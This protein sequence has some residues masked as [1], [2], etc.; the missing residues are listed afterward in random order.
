MLPSA[1]V[2]TYQQYKLDTDSV[3]AWLAST[4]KSLGYSADLLDS[5]VAATSTSKPRASGG[6]LKGKARSN[7]KKT[8]AAGASSFAP[9]PKPSGPK[10]VISVRSFVSLAE[11]IAEKAAPVPEVF[12]TVIDRVIAARSKFGGQ[13]RD[14][15]EAIDP[16]S[17]AKHQHFVD[18]LA[19]VRSVLSPLMPAV[20][21]EDGQSDAARLAN[22]FTGLAVYEP[23]QEF[24]NLPDVARPG[25]AQNDDSTYEAQPERSF[26]EAIFALDA[27]INDLGHV[28]SHIR[29]IWSNHKDG[30]FEV[31]PAAVATDTA[32]AL[33]R[34]LIDE[35]LPLLEWNGGIGDLLERYYLL[36]CIVQGWKLEDLKV[37]A[38]V[39]DNFNYKTYDIADGTYLLP[40]RLLEAFIPVV[41]ERGQ[42]PIYKEGMFGY[43]DPKSNRS[44]KTGLQKF[45]DDRALL[46]PFFS[47]I[48]TA[49]RG[50]DNWP[51]K[52]E[53]Y[54]GVEELAKTKKVPFYAAFAAQIFLD[55]TYELGEHVERG[56]DAFQE[57]TN[58]MNNDVEQHFEFHSKLKI[59]SW[60]AAHDQMLREFQKSIQ[61]LGKDPLRNVQNRLLARMGAPAS[62]MPMYLIF[63][64]SPVVSGLM[65]FHFRLVYSHVGRAVADAWGSVQYAQ[66]LYNAACREGL[67]GREDRWQDMEVLYANLGEG[68]FYVGGEAPKTAADYFKK[69]SLQMGTSAAAMTGTRRR[70]APLASGAGPRGLKEGCPVSCMFKGRYVR[71]QIGPSGFL[72]PERVDQIIDLSLFEPIEPPNDG[73]GDGLVLGRIEHPAILK[74]KAKKTMAMGT[75]KQQRKKAA[76]GGR[77]TPSQLIQ[78]LT[79]ALQAETL[80]LAFPLL[81]FHRWCWRLLR[82]VKESCDSLLTTRYGPGYLETERQLPFVVGWILMAAGGLGNDVP[83]RRM[84]EIAAG[85]IGE[86]GGCEAGSIVSEKILG[87]IFD[88]PI[89]FEEEDA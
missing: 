21:D 30:L 13:L 23:S 19:K 47:E 88:M 73:K 83:D 4:A 52:D 86:L 18:V 56:F 79:W 48:A 75:N 10:Y 62:T 20:K 84:L 46:M 63:R 65:L 32:V 24:L 12:R 25:T 82:S 35:V 38:N 37:A 68:S 70:G 27:L 58:F 53:L 87:N 61:W 3:A 33:A 59:K 71:G 41:E 43:W 22:R 11:Y 72:T 29:W 5:S 49:M 26:E 39:K 80:E 85:V 66:H 81:T 34:G 7:A 74:E 2:S 16:G 64:M 44:L 36:R 76:D 89:V 45:E 15:G 60:T 42:V 6:R 67:V 50:V 31:A 14:Y 55:I 78:P 51:V 17:D 57:Q 9:A 40:Y 69:F 77:V 54:Q 8:A 1:L 28:R